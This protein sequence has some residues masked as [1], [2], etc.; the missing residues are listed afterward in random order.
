MDIGHSTADHR[1][2]NF[3]PD[4]ASLSISSIARGRYPH[5]NM[6]STNPSILA[7]DVWFCRPRDG[8]NGSRQKL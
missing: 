2:L 8:I 4:R 1:S 7:E 3:G 6:I 5:A